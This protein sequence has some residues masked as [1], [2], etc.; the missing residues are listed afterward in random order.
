M[1]QIIKKDLAVSV[2]LWKAL[3]E[4]C[5]ERIAMADNFEI[6]ARW[7]MIGAY[8]TFIYVLSLRGP[9]G[10]QVEISL[11][12]KH[13][14]LRNGLVWIPLVG[15]LKGDSQPG[16]FFL[17]SVPYTGSGI[18]VLLW[19]DRLLVIHE[20]AGREAGPAFCDDQGFLLSSLKVNDSMWDILEELYDKNP[21]LF[22]KAIETKAMIRDLIQINRS[23]R[24]SSESQATKA[25]PY[26]R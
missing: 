22:P 21:V 8:L 3:L 13:K 26:Q 16:I 11:L 20:M 24:R 4:K 19:R 2:D 12:R 25:K 9:E 5:E 7:T 1:G 15:K 6:G 14:E 17:R 23:G 10:F 18:D